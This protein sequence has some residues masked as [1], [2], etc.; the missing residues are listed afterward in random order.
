MK[1]FV[2]L[3]LMVLPASLLAQSKDQ[4]YYELR[5][6]YCHP[7][8]LD[9]LVTRFT[10]HTASLFEKHGMTNVGYWLPVDNKDNA[11]YYV[12][13][14]PD[15]AT[16][17]A[18]WKAFL[19]DTTWKRVSSQSELNG[20]IVA[21]VVSTFMNTADISPEIKNSSTG[22]DRSFELRTYFIPEGRTEE[23]LTRFR[24]HSI[25][26]LSKHGASHIAYWVTAEASGQPTRLIYLLAYPSAEAGAKTWVDFRKDPDWI[27]AKAASEKEHPLVDKVESVV[28]KPMTISKIR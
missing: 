25:R 10:D 27:R 17:D 3:F 16:R 2:I 5:V 11:L 26:L 14:Y 28:L 15:K 19:A 24:N 20:K 12:L 22:S 1:F 9:A 8:K 7:G 13:C 23:L 21:K 4:K 6:Y 18:S